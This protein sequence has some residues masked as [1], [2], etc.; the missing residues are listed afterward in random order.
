MSQEENTKYNNLMNKIMNVKNIY[1]E[2]EKKK[3]LEK[4]QE[5]NKDCQNIYEAFQKTLYD[6]LP[7]KLLQ[8]EKEGIIYGPYIKIKNEKFPDY[9][10]DYHIDRLSPIYKCFNIN[11]INKIKNDVYNIGEYIHDKNGVKNESY[12]FIGLD[13]LMLVPYYTHRVKIEKCNP[14][15]FDDF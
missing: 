1:V 5:F 10:C 14:S 6:I 7:N 11:K 2:K 15:P 4:N 12:Y 3:E 13:S 9:D 8:L